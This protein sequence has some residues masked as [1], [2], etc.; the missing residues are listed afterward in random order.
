[1]EKKQY[2]Q[3]GQGYKKL[4]QTLLRRF[5]HDAT[6]EFY[7]PKLIREMKVP[8]NSALDLACGEGRYTRRLKQMG[9]TRVVGTD[10]S[11]EMIQMAKE[12]ELAS[13]LGVEYF[14]GDAG[15]RTRWGEF[16]LATA[17]FLLHYA[18]SKEHL[19]QM[20]VTIADNLKKG[21]VFIAYQSN[22]FASQTRESLDYG[23]IRRV[24]GEER[25]GADIEVT[26]IDGQD[27]INFIRK[28]WKPETYEVALKKAGFSSVQWADPV[29]S[30]QG[31]AEKGRKFWQ[32]YQ[33]EP[34]HKAI[35]CIK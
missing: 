13:P 31:I 23:E 24:V 28:L 9:F 4:V 27:R 17:W 19:E 32:Q 30:K 8:L 6:F 5:V 11:E 35:I 29:I 2:N 18:N 7:V 25:E 3:I 21:G 22:P 34:G 14:V 16:D 15:S 12:Q 1:M 10:I 20:C 33:N 26:L